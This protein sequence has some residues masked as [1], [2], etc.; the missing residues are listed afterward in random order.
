LLVEAIHG[1][2]GIL[3]ALKRFNEALFVSCDRPSL[4]DRTILMRSTIGKTCC[5]N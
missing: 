1:R 2:A 3:H 4:C 5:G